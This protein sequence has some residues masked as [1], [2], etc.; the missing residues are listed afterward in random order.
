MADLPFMQH[1][2]L[3]PEETEIRAWLKLNRDKALAGLTPIEVA[4]Y[5]VRYGGFQ[6]CDVIVTLSHFRDAIQGSHIDNRAALQSY[7]MDTAV[8]DFMK[9]RDALERPKE[10]DLMPLWMDVYQYQ[11]GETQEAI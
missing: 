2:S 6:M 5:A 7:L 3:S 8:E 4:N 10:L 11:T 9:C 1:R